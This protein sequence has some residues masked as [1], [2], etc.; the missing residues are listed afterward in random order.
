[1]NIKRLFLILY[2]GIFVSLTSCTPGSCFEKTDS[3]LDVSFYDFATRKAKT[4]DSLTVFGLGFDTNTIYSAS[5]SIR[6][7]SLPLNSA[8]DNSVFIMRINNF[9]DTLYV[10]YSSYPHLISKECGYTF[11]HQ[12][13][14][15]L[16]SRNE[17]EILIN[18]RT[19]TN[20]DEENIRIY[21]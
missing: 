4:P 13:D 6:K 12:I 20:L 17:I 9:T 3:L 10:F 21:Y 14:S 11:Y 15:V 18:Q 19:V 1:M 8:S 5:K 2:A 7:A 16:H